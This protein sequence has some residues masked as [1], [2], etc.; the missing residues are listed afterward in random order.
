MQTAENDPN[1]RFKFY[2]KGFR[3]ILIDD[4]SNLHLPMFDLQMNEVLGELQNWSANLEAKVKTPLF[5][6]F[7]NIKNSHWEPVIEPVLING[8]VKL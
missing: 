4:L 6:N 8:L 2:L 5:F 1:E 7:F 3:V